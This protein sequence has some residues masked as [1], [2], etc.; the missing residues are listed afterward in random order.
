MEYETLDFFDFLHLGDNSLTLV[1]LSQEQWSYQAVRHTALVV[2]SVV[3]EE[4]RVW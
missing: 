1:P 3:C 4:V 2:K